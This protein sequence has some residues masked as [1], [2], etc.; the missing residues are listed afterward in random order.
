MLLENWFQIIFIE[1]K[2]IWPKLHKIQYFFLIF[3]MSVVFW[4]LQ[5][6][7]KLEI[8]PINSVFLGLLISS[9]LCLSKREVFD[10]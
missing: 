8:I 3:N 1:Q 6:S 7:F 4:C 9:V 5:I 10:Y 2:R